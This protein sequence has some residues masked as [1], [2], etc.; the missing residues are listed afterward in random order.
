[1]VENAVLTAYR[2]KTRDSKIKYYDGKYWYGYL[3]AETIELLKEK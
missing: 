1:M 3:S 2:N